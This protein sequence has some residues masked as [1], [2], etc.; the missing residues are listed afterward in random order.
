MPPRVS[1]TASHGGYRKTPF[2]GK[3]YKNLAYL[4]R[5]VR[6]CGEKGV[7]LRRERGR[8]SGAKVLRQLEP[9]RLIVRADAAAVELVRPRQHFF[10]HEPA[11]DLAMFEDER[12]FA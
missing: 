7:V 1:R 11:D 8:L 2:R 4:V 3:Y 9:L 6:A 12:H 5:D 10:V